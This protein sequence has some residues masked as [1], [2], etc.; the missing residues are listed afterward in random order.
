[1]DAQVSGDLSQ[2][3]AIVISN[4]THEA[5]GLFLVVFISHHMAVKEILEAVVIEQITIRISFMLADKITE[6]CHITVGKRALV[7][8][9]LN[10][11]VSQSIFYH[12]LL[13]DMRRHIII[14]EVLKKMLPNISS[15]PFILQ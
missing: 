9:L 10:Y 12:N 8:V 1:M 7:D 15:R 11:Q 3:I 14:D 4:R 5:Y 13:P 2:N 6:A